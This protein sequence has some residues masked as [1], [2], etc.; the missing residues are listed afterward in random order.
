M[1]LLI[2]YSINKISGNK[3]LFRFFKFVIVSFA[4]VISP[5][6]WSFFC[7]YIIYLTMAIFKW[8]DVDYDY[9]G[10]CFL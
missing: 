7:K 9:I 10:W 2:V 6:Y 1:S 8:F 3:H 5:L 4:P